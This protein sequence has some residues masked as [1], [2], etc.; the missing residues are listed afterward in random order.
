MQCSLFSFVFFPTYKYIPVQCCSQASTICVLSVDQDLHLYNTIKKIP[1][2]YSF[3]M[4]NS[5]PTVTTVCREGLTVL[6]IWRAMLSG[7]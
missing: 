2:L 4:H 1:L 6:I 3:R 5:Y 7:S